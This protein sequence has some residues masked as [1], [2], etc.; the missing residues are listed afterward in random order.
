MYAYL[1]AKPN[2]YFIYQIDDDI[3]YKLTSVILYDIGTDLCYS[4]LMTIVVMMYH[5]L[6]GLQLLS[7]ME[8]D[9][10][11]RKKRISYIALC[12]MI[13]CKIIETIVFTLMQTGLLQ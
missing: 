12:L 7:G 4:I 8:Y 13:L 2:Q 10:M 1:Y 11:E 6:L 9:V 5:L 3:N